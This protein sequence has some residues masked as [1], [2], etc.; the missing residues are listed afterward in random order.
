MVGTEGWGGPQAT[1][2][3]RRAIVRA[4]E[5]VGVGGG[6]YEQRVGNDVD[7]GSRF[8]KRGVLQKRRKGPLVKLGGCRGLVNTSN[9]PRPLE[10]KKRRREN[11]DQPESE[12]L[13][14]QC[15]R[16]GEHDLS[17]RK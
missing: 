16:H 12:V 14:A 15:L 10:R 13:P 2:N 17:I 1:D 5:L 9:A 8:N 3:P 6:D 7:G 11:L 4:S